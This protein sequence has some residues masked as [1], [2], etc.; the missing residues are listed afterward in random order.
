MQPKADAIERVLIAGDLSKLSADDRIAYYMRVCESAGL[1]P[2]T[3]P[4]D[5]ITLSGKLTLYAKKGCT[6][7]LRTI[8]KIS[9]VSM[10]KDESEGVLTVTA[11][12]SNAEGRTDVD[13][14][15]VNIAGLKGEARA[16]AIMKA[17]TKAKR[18]AT[19]SI[20][21]LGLLDETEIETIP[22][23]APAEPVVAKVINPETGRVINPNNARNSREKWG[24]FCERVR[25]FTDLDALEQWWADASTQAAVDQMPWAQEAA[26]EYEKAQERLMNAG[27]P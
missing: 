5:Y 24:R 17:S 25:G 6:D 1:N 3:Q 8:H 23:V 7:Q 13:M 11:K 16:N 19:L 14:G 22:N 21:G 27:R 26:E 2:L 10:E 12:V 9:V 18:R 4:F 15:S 20:C